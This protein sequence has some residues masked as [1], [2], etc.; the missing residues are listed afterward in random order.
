M[1]A[2]GKEPEPTNEELAIDELRKQTLL[3]S[4][5]LR[6]AKKKPIQTKRKTLNDF[7][8]QDDTHVALLQ[9]ANA[10]YNQEIEKFNKAFEI[11]DS[12]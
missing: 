1:S 11:G 8:N 7:I 2:K 9:V 12:V 6:E 4:Q 5:Q 10:A 3:Q